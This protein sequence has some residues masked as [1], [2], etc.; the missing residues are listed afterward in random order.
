M[1]GAQS[2]MLYGAA[3]HT[4]TLIAQHARQGGHQPVLAG[5]NAAAVAALAEAK[6]WL[7]NLTTE[8]MEGDVAA[9]ER[10]QKRKLVPQHGNEVSRNREFA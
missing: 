8:K 3:G 9:L 7:R 2:W 10:G 1:S 4:G 5:R 6:E